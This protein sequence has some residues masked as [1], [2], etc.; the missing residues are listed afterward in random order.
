MSQAT[1]LNLAVRVRGLKKHFGSGN[2]TIRVLRGL[3]MDIQANQLMML[4]GPSG[5]GKTTLL[6]I[7]CGVLD[8]DGGEADLFGVDWL[9]LR[10]AQR[11][12]RR[13]EMVGYVFQ[14]FNLIPTLSAV[15]NV[16]VPLM[17]RR[18]PQARCL[19]LA[20]EQLAHVGLGDR[21]NAMPAQLSGG[22]Q[23]RVAIA[24]ALVGKPRL[25]VAD[26]PTA[27]LDG[28]TGQKIMQLLKDASRPPP[29]Q[30]ARC[31]IVVTHDVRMFHHADRIEQMEDGRLSGALDPRQYETPTHHPHHAHVHAPHSPH[32]R[33]H[34]SGAVAP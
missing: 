31:V 3:D 27:N 26:E 28:Q 20:A 8:A 25:L 7:L 17:I 34:D 13:R 10:D 6:S 18:L 21:L 1:E 32:P 16:A 15:E 5:C 14:Q 19:E 30:D 12:I 33:T 24:R 22:Q 2:A 4:V 29:G 11:T 23:Q 9:K